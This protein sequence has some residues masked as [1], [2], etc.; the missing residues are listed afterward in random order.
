MTRFAGVQEITWYVWYEGAMDEGMQEC[1]R[2]GVA[3][4][5]VVSN[6]IAQRFL[7][8]SLSSLPSTLSKMPPQRATSRRPGASSIQGGEGDDGVACV[9]C[10]AC[11]VGMESARSDEC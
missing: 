7:S 3:T 11:V 1:K 9:A 10:V 2:R 4:A 8:L 5:L 6:G